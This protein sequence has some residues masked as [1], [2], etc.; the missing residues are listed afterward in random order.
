M[1]RAFRDIIPAPDGDACSL[2]KLADSAPLRGKMLIATRGGC[3]FLEKSRNASAVNASALIV[4]NNAS[5]LFHIAAGYATGSEYLDEVDVPSH[6]PV[7]RN[8]TCRQTRTTVLT[9]HYDHRFFC[10][11][12][13]MVKQHALGALRDACAERGTLSGRMIPLKCRSGEI[14]CLPIL[15]EEKQITQEIDSGMLELTQELDEFEFLTGS[16]FLL[17][18]PPSVLTLSVTVLTPLKALGEEYCL[19]ARCLRRGWTQWMAA[20]RRIGMT[21]SQT[22]SRSSRGGDAASE[23]RR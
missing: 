21:D 3:S 19:R 2:D 10:N 20:C 22:A 13:I 17:V 18:Q 6:L 12:K 5:G 16:Q 1:E 11:P 23:K 9:I 4:V 14:V 8:V 7:V 15:E